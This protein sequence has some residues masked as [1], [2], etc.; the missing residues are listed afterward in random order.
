MVLEQPSIEYCEDST[1]IHAISDK[2][3]QITK[4][5]YLTQLHNLSKSMPFRFIS[6]LWRWHHREGHHHSVRILLP[7]L[8]NQQGAHSTTG[9]PSQRMGNLESLQA[10]GTFGFL[11]HHIQDTVDELSALRVVAL[12]P[13]VT[14]PCLSE[15]KVIG[16]ENVT[17]VAAAYGVHGTGLQIHQHSTRDVTA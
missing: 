2:Y 1:S 3:Y 10:I 6:Y 7:D 12:S 5:V 4:K 17:V 9:T 8:R 11:P 13:V 16:S 14:R 15:N